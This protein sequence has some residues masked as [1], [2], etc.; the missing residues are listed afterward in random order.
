[1]RVSQFSLN[2][3]SRTTLHEG[4]REDGAYRDEIKILAPDGTVH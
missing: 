3:V 1:M 4:E 2:S